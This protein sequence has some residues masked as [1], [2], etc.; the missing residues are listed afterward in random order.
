MIRHFRYVIPAAVAAVVLAGGGAVYA[1]GPGAGGPRGRGPGM[2]PG[3]PPAGLALRAL[4]LTD[5]QRE[6]VRQLT[7][8]HR[9]QTRALFEHGQRAPYPH[10]D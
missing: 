9:E 8:Q 1:Q 4:D 7:R 10:D 3:G 2:G 5:A 6:Q